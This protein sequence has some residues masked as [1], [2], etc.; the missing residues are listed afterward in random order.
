[1][2]KIYEQEHKSEEKKHPKNKILSKISLK[3]FILQ[4]KE[5]NSG[6]AV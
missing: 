5:I 3:N 2:D 4:T 6:G 1:M